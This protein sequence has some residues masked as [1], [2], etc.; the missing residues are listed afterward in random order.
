MGESAVRNIATAISELNCARASKLLTRD[1]TLMDRF[2]CEPE[3]ENVDA[4]PTLVT[5]R[6]CAH[7][8]SQGRGDL[9]CGRIDPFLVQS[10]AHHGGLDSGAT[11]LRG[12]ERQ[13]LCAY[14]S[15]V[16]R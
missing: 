10:R 2:Y 9:G 13:Q 7:L 6:L 5:Q 8:Y 11:Q 1:M 4:T 16:G 14:S 12:R 15:K 3:T